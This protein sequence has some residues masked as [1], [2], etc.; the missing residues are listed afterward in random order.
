MP[1]DAKIFGECYELYEKYRTILMKTDDQW[2]QLTADISAF[3]ERNDWENNPLTK[4]L[5]FALLDV[6]SDMYRDGKRPE[7]PDYLGRSDLDGY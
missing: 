6:F 4:R 2:K 1:E 5:G 7:M 3:A